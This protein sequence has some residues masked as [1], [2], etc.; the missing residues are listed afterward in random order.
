MSQVIV[1]RA[2]G[3]HPTLVCL[4]VSLALAH[5]VKAAFVEA[6]QTWP[7]TAPATWEVKDLSGA[8]YNVPANAVVEVA[9]RNTNG[10]A[11]R[12]GG[13]RAVGSGLER[14]V[15]LHEAE[16]GGWDVVVMHVQTDGSSQIEHYSDN[17]AEVDFILLGYWTCASYVEAYQVFKAGAAAAW[18]DHDLVAYGVEADQVAEIV[19]VNNKA[20]AERQAGVR[21][22]GSALVRLLNLHE[23]ESGGDEVATMFVTADSTANAT[24]EVYAQ[25]NTDID[26]Y[27]V[28]YWS[29]PP[30]TFTELLAVIGSPT[31]DATWEAK[32]LSP[33][34]LPADAVAEIVFANEQ[35]SAENN[36]G[37]RQTGSSLG[38]FLDLQEPEGGGG[39]FGRMHVAAD[40]SSTIEFYH[41]DVSDPHSFGLTG[42]WV[43]VDTFVVADHEAGQEFD[44]FTESGGETQAE[45]FGFKL[46]TC[47][48]V[49]I[50]ELVFRL[51]N[52]TGL[53]DF[54]WSL[55][56]V[57]VDDD[58]DGTLDPGETTAVGG[59]GI[60]DQASGTITFSSSFPVA[61]LTNYILRADFS[62][63]SDGDTVT[64]SLLDTDI[65]ATETF[66]GS[67]TQVGHREGC[68]YVDQYQSWSATAPATWEV[69]DLQA[70]PLH[71][72]P[73]VVAE[74][75]VRN[76]RVDAQRWGGVRAVGSALERRF[77]LHEPEGGGEDV[78][79]MHVQ[80]DG[81]SRIEQYAQ[82][83]DE[84]QFTL[85]GFWDCGTYV[86]AYQSFN[87]GASAS[88]Q[89]HDLSPYGV[90]SQAVAEVVMVNSSSVNA[91]E[92][93]VRRN[94]SSLER[95]IAVHE[96]EGGGGEVATMFVLA[97]ASAN[98]TIEVYAENDISIDFYLVGYWSTPPSGFTEAFVDIGSP[99]VDSTWQDVSLSGFGVPA[100][101]VV[102][103]VLANTQVDAQ[104]V[105]GVRGNGSSL[106]RTV[107]L[108]ESEPFGGD[109]GRMQVR[110]DASS[111]I[112][113]FHDSVS[114]AHNFW[115]TGYW[116]GAG[117]PKI[118]GWREVSPQ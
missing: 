70:S 84:V 98:A 10:S 57:I 87:A 42:Y 30:G 116:Q 55:V 52:I 12:W 53:T 9:V 80:V 38:R 67:T 7:A 85:L 90:G 39:D 5:P 56:D 71:V 36:M 21:T 27:L 11:E 114:A 31:A 118:V 101:T 68:F 46:D 32:D 89:D 3:V 102:E 115:L 51:S 59:S 48:S 49:T 15:L 93:G 74:V 8:P 64:I 99:S 60:V 6:Y 43:Y 97:D 73:N 83:T 25:N 65:T 1:A 109:F 28:G 69:K 17:I 16:D 107:D 4:G 77:Q 72:P 50:N 76:S 63:L 19:M 88:W 96:A 2:G 106:A 58:D 24:I 40:V 29:K 112:E 94:G 44:A 91:W 45:L 20:S 41:E 110:A 75:A 117:P 78:V 61:A 26:F 82:V 104:H 103:L 86:E 81:S 22:N 62:E 105:M 35:T 113:F 47:L 14:R 108:Q 95:R 13:V 92:A 100:D 79:V 33:Y 37:V 34:G 18:K 54:D 66:T 23:A 111:T